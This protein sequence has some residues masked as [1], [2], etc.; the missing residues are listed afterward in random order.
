MQDLAAAPVDPTLR[1]DLETTG[2]AQGLRV[3][4]GGE[5]FFIDG[6]PE[7]KA[8]ADAGDQTAIDIWNAARGR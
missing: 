4:P 7:L 2:K 8:I 1:V 5:Y 6:D 3:E